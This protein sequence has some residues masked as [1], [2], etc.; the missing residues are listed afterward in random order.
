MSGVNGKWNVT[1]NTPM[2]AQKSTLS[3][4]V[5]GTTLTGKMEGAQ[6]ALDIKDGKANGNDLSWTADLT[7]PMPIKLEFSGKVDGDKISG[8]VKLGAFGNASFSGTRA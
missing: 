7:Q 6:G 1:M 3:L 5:S 8:S 4:T 2:G